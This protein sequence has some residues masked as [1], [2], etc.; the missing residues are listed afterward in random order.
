[1][2][3]SRVADFLLGTNFES[4]ECDLRECDFRENDLRE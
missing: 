2:F 1:M 3:K 4:K